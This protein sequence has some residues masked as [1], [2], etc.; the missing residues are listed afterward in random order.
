MIAWLK[1]QS[2]VSL[3]YLNILLE[4]WG[5]RL[6]DVLAWVTSKWVQPSIEILL[7]KSRCS[8]CIYDA[9][10]DTRHSLKA[11]LFV[12]HQPKSREAP[13]GIAAQVT[14]SPVHR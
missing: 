10:G 6:E 5:H 2:H 13:T 3:I 8:E 12:G 11:S 1:Y 7:L 9:L 4:S 14:N